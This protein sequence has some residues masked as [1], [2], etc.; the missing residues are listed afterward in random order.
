MPDAFRHPNQLLLPDHLS[1][2]IVWGYTVM[3]VYRRLH[4][5]YTELLGFYP[6]QGNAEI[7]KIFLKHLGKFTV[8]VIYLEF[9]DSDYKLEGLITRSTFTADPVNKSL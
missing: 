4:R 3:G 9:V 6:R 5:D 7:R 8:Q 1:H 2:L